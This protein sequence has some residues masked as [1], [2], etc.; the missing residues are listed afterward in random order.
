MEEDK[1]YTLEEF[2]IATDEKELL[3]Q[4]PDCDFI[5]SFSPKFPSYHYIS[6]LRRENLRLKGEIERAYGIGFQ[7]GQ[8][9][10]YEASQNERKW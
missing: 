4:H 10:G 1:E 6:L 9:N 8:Q 5:S 3:L 7:E 2:N